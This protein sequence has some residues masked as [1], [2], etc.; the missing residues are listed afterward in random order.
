MSGVQDSVG[1]LIKALERHASVMAGTDPAPVDAVAAEE[2]VRAAAR[3]YAMAVMEHNGWGHPFNDLF[4]TDESE[5]PEETEPTAADVV[6]LSV[7]G[8]WDFYVEDPAAWS[9]FVEARMA[10]LGLP[11]CAPDLTDPAYALGQLVAHDDF[12]RRLTGHGLRDGGSDVF[13][14]RIEQTLAEESE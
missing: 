5:E 7:E 9:S 1:L 6:R 3:A 2:A 11:D 14:G 10:E 4:A 8:R 12:S 13:S